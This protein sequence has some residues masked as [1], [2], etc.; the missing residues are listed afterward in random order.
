[1]A[2]CLCNPPECGTDEGLISINVTGNSSTR[3]VPG[4]NTVIPGPTAGNVT[5]N[6][7]AFAAGSD[8]WLGVR[9][10]STAQGSQTNYIRYD[11]CRDKFVIIPST[12]NTASVVG[13]DM[14]GVSFDEFGCTVE[15]NT[16]YIQNGVTVGTT[17]NMRFGKDLQFDKVGG[18]PD[19]SA[20]TVAGAGPAFL[21]NL[22]VRSNFP[23]PAQF[24]A[25]YQF[26]IDC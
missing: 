8:L 13:E 17:S 19:I 20:K 6:G 10:P 11:G 3:V 1:M 5:L 12:V 16:A 25:S 4:T 22:S 14:D 24:S 15:T 7:Y 2:F 18:F 26:M 23:Q 21:Q 9:C